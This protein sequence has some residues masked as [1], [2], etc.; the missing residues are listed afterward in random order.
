MPE[1][2][3]FA[4][5][6]RDLYREN[7]IQLTSVGIDIGSSTTLIVFSCLDL[8]RE[9]SR[10]VTVNRKILYESEIILTPYI[11]QL[12]IDGK[13]LN[14]FFSR[15]YEIAGLNRRD[16]DTGALILTGV[17]LLRENARIIAD[18]FAQEAGSFVSVSAG[19]NLEATLAAYGSGASALS[20]QN[21]GTILN[22][23]VGGGTTKFAVCFDGK[24]MNI[25]AMNIGARL[26]V[27]DQN[28]NII[29]ME[30]AGRRICQA[31]GLDYKIGSQI[32]TD[33]IRRITGYMTDRLFEVICLGQLSKAGQELM[34]TQ[35]LTYPGQVDAVTFSGGVS[36][37][38][39]DRNAKHFGDLGP[40]LAEEIKKRIAV[41]GIR[42]I[43]PSA[44]IK[45]TVVGA[46][47]YVLQ[48]S[49]ATIFLLP[50]DVVPIHNI[51]VI[52]PD[53]GLDQENVDPAMIQKS[54]DYA[55]K[56]FDLTDTESPFAIAFHWEGS[57]T[58][59]RISSLCAGIVNGIKDVLSKGN[60]VVLVNDGDIGGLVGIHLKEEMHL[61][62]PVI[63]VDGI[64]LREFDY[65]DIGD[66]IT[67]SGAV[68]VV[69]KSLVFNTP[70]TH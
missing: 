2:F 8:E 58:H 43:Q 11:E 9:N 47:Q 35:P 4:G 41:T 54:L 5:S 14:H 52:T 53:F 33:D 56:C 15:Q 66:L 24:I 55:L 6:A 68:P 38:I 7:H 1:Y 44:G 32:N 12:K 30:E 51:P 31:M 57:A 18:L 34:R 65:I 48:V 17:A 69:I 42:V 21:C 63:S 22:V 64:D 16:V 40:I 10:Y 46:S 3:R 26:L 36:E 61:P 45:A 19:D 50:K 25:A 70:I 60:P 27:W 37:Y 23:D 67:H 49:G 13:S 20:I 59:A 39:Y 28:N 62:N 29:R